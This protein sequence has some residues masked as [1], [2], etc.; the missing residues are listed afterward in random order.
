MIR[1]TNYLIT[2]AVI[3]DSELKIIGVGLRTVGDKA[4]QMTELQL[5]MEPWSNPQALYVE[6]LKTVMAS[7]VAR[8]HQIKK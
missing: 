3:I 2:V 7:V 1:F 6:N 5:E 8:H 4:K